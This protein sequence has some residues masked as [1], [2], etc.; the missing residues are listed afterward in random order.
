M[1]AVVHLIVSRAPDFGEN[2]LNRC[3]HATIQRKSF[4]GLRVGRKRQR[5][6][7]F[8]LLT[9]EGHPSSIRSHQMMIKLTTASMRL[10]VDQRTSYDDWLH[11]ADVIFVVVIMTLRE[12]RLSICRD[13]GIAS[14]QPS[15]HGNNSL[16]VL[17]WNNRRISSSRRISSAMAWMAR[18]LGLILSYLVVVVD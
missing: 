10:A 2:R 4:F 6:N 15:M 7:F 5:H 12:S 1:V 3:A 14:S 17:W 8:C 9:A 13:C 16:L 18:L 11:V